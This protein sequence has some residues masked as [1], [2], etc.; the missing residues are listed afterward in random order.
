MRYSPLYWFSRYP[1]KISP[2]W[3][4]LK[5]FDHQTW[6]LIFVSILSV[7]LC[8]GISARIGSSYF[9]IRT[10]TEEIA[11]SP[12]R[13]PL[14]SD[15]QSSN[16]N[17]KIFEIVK[18]IKIFS[19]SRVLRIRFP[20]GFSSR[21]LFLLWCVCGGFLLH[22]SSSLLLD[23]LLK[24][25]YEKPI[26]TAQDILDRGFKIIAGPGAVAMVLSRKNS[27]SNITRKLAENTIIAEV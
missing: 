4:L 13:V 7:T 10:F 3:N 8:F 15:Q 23:I 12:F 16:S 21:M 27:L 2:T 25:N 19:F 11:L 26:D 9:G 17:Y 6:I 5:L 14:L 22:F 1:S 24:K 20:F 18:R